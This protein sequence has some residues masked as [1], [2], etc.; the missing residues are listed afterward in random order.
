SNNLSILAKQVSRLMLQAKIEAAKFPRPL[1]DEIQEVPLRHQRDELA[2][3]GNASE[4]RSLKPV[5]ANH[6]A[7]RPQLLVRHRQ[8]LVQNSEFVHQFQC[9]GMDRVSAKIAKEIFMLFEHRNVYALARQQIP[10]HH[11][12]RPATHNATRSLKRVRHSRRLRKS[13]CIGRRIE[14]ASP[15]PGAKATATTSSSKPEAASGACRSSPPTPA[16]ST[17]THSTP[18]AESTAAATRPTTSTSSSATSS[19]LSTI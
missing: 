3:R 9:R 18:A 16:P 11:A 14:S 13:H 1:R 7:D 17:D 5:P 6:A 2:M 8:E 19:P 15:N 10:Q 12:R 4:I